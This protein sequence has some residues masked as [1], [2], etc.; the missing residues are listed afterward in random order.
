MSVVVLKPDLARP[1]F[2][3]CALKT[4][5]VIM[6]DG[7]NAGVSVKGEGIIVNINDA[8]LYIISAVIF[9]L[10]FGVGA[11]GIAIALLPGFLFSYFLIECGKTVRIL[12]S[13]PL[14]VALVL[15][16]TWILGTLSVPVS[17]TLL[18][19]LS[20]AYSV[21]FGFVLKNSKIHPRPNVAA[22]S[23]AVLALL[24]V[25]VF[26][27]YPLHNGLLP[28]TDGSAHYY[29]IG[30]L[31]NSI[32]G[33]GQIPM[34][35]ANW[36][37]GYPLFDFYPPMSY[38]FAVFISYFVPAGMNLVF[39]YVTILSYMFL[40]AGFFVLARGLGMNIF[41]SFL[42]GLVAVS[43]PRLAA[44]TMFSGQFPTILA[45]SLVPVSLYVFKRAFEEGKPGLY[46]LS[47]MLL[48]ANLVIHNLTGYFMGIMLVLTFLVSLARSRRVERG[49]AVGFLKAV[50]V[51]VL[52][53]SFWTVPFFIN[54]S[55]N[56]YFSQ[57]VTGFN[58]DIFLVLM[59]SPDKSCA[60]FYC[61]IAMGA[62]FTALAL[63]G[64]LVWL[65]GASLGRGK[66]SL[67]P[68][69][70]PGSAVVISVLI[71]TLLMAVSPFLGIS[72]FLPFGS[73]GAERFV[74]YLV[75]PIALFGGAVG[76][77]VNGFK[78]REFLIAGLVLSLA[79]GV[80][81]LGY[82]DLV[83]FRAANWNNEAAPLASSGLSDMYSELNT[84]PPGR[85]ITYGI[86]QA[87]IVS[88][89]PAQTNKPMISGWHPPGSPNY[90]DVAGRIED[91][92]GQGLFNFNVSGKFV[93]TMF[94]NSW[95]RWIVV[96]LCS[97]E[98]QRALDST[99]IKDERYL[100]VW[101]N[102][103]NQGCLVVLEV[104]GVVFAETV[105]VAGAEGDSRK[106]MDSIYD[107]ENG[108]LVHFTKQLGEIPDDEY[109]IIIGKD[110]LWDA[111]LSKEIAYMASS[112][113]KPLEWKRKAGEIAVK[114]TT[115]WTLVKETYYPTWS[116]WNGDKEVAI[117]ENDL[118]F[119]LV[120]SE[121]DLVL[122]QRIPPENLLASAASFLF[123]V[124]LLASGVL[125]KF[126]PHNA[127]KKS[128]PVPEGA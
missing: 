6:K 97:D 65:S 49:K 21:L 127:G 67:S 109:K 126:S 83:N 35:D 94:Q 19:L 124:C 2:Y 73:L 48:G 68:H 110:V 17:G 59:K 85:V 15:V 82:M 43:S 108:Y 119:M 20:V 51:A 78:G 72:K 47:G 9:Y 103:N 5:S 7:E 26:V 46:V 32:D 70:D 69:V 23:F 105:T 102:G 91:V 58:Q 89:I 63:V 42:A 92:S 116:A 12:L 84:L 95:T 120:K 93:Y 86:F 100:V 14:S 104:P 1:L 16:P 121:G 61:F 107:T 106:I 64:G 52:L 80:F 28:R 3:I 13:V 24:A 29:K 113:R 115:G 38:Y 4:Y 60:D 114:N 22:E 75:L 53:S 50:F 55:H 118:G 25:A 44:N 90:Q 18:V 33:S 122:K 87:A 56:P 8:G 66:M 41:S 40:A 34:W 101:R 112:E 74:F 10:A 111:G 54:V 27:T 36:Y 79:V 77:I 125:E 11:V 39:N 98:G 57:K 123:F 31:K 76:E 96:N 62:E 88:G 117:H 37:A 71:V 81:L 99:F 45:F 30:L 128:D